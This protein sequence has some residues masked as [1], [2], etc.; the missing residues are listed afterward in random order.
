MIVQDGTVPITV[1]VAV[2]V[3]VFPLASVTVNVTV[4]LPIL[5]HVNVDFDKASV[6]A[7]QLS[8][9]PLL[10]WFGVM[11]AVPLARVTVA[12]LQNAFGFSLSVTVTVNV[13]ETDGLMP[14][15]AVHVTVV[16]PLLSITF[17]SELPLPVVAPLNV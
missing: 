7:P 6:I 5:A 3:C 17:A 8:E 15:L 9:L 12:F 16:V 1:T 10:M 13:Q 2:Q 4:L 11:E 14:S